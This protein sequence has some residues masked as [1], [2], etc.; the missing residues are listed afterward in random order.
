MRG[1]RSTGHRWRPFAVAAAVA[2]G[3]VVAVVAALTAWFP[4]Q[5]ARPAAPSRA[6]TAPLAGLQE[7]LDRRAAAAARGDEQG[8]LADLDPAASAYR[9]RQRR[10]LA[11]T[12]VLPVERVGF[13]VVGPTATTTPT[14]TT[15]ATTATS[16]TSTTS[17]TT[18]TTVSSDSARSTTPPGTLVVDVIGRWALRGYDAEV[19]SYP[20]R[21]TVRHSGTS[22]LLVDDDDP[23]T[24][25]QLFDLPRVGV[26]ATPDGLVAGS[27]DARR[28][29]DYASALGAARRTVERSWGSGA[30]PPVV[31]VPATTAEFAALTGRDA[32]RSAEVGAVTSGLLQ[33]GRVARGDR[34]VINPASWPR[35]GEQGRRIILTHELT[36]LLVRAS[37]THAVP[38]WLSEG[39]AVHVSYAGLDVDPRKAAPE[40]LATVRQ[41]RVPSTLPGDGRF[42][43]EVTSGAYDEAWLVVEHLVATRGEPA[44]TRFYRDLGSG[45]PAE[46]AW[47]RLGT[48]PDE[49]LAG[50]QQRLRDLAR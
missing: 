6:S 28:L 7:V 36:H 12:Q 38:Q 16:S 41:G 39:Y 18:A 3:L 33:T 13:Q 35:L 22:W 20:L 46:Q 14:A 25:R 11:A 49:L 32:A 40:L 29:D 21:L 2:G 24:A 30:R 50:W 31:V 15:P 42:G 43:Q 26:R 48:T 5:P 4:T 9:D 47:S 45:M 27:A 17:T 44:V 23:G 34:V 1:A 8:W 19:A 10:V 37:T